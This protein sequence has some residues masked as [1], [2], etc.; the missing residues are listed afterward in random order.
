MAEPTPLE[1]VV[2][3]RLRAKVNEARLTQANAARLRV[4]AAL[5]E[6]Q[7]AVG[8]QAAFLE[9]GIAF[10]P[11]TTGA[12]FNDQAERLELRPIPPAGPKE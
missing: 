1:P 2:Y 3:W 6:T 12:E 9:A 5:L 11:A 7:A 10:D 4:E 8:A